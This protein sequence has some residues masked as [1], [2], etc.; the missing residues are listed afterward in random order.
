MN[1]KIQNWASCSFCPYTCRFTKLC[2]P[3][4]SMLITWLAVGISHCV[5]KNVGLEPDDIITCLNCFALLREN[6]I[7]RLALDK[8]Q[9]WFVKCLNVQRQNIGTYIFVFSNVGITFNMP[10]SN[11]LSVHPPLPDVLF[12][13]WFLLLLLQ[14]DFH[15]SDIKLLSILSISSFIWDFQDCFWSSWNPKKTNKQKKSTTMCC[16]VSNLL[17]FS[18]MYQSYQFKVY[19]TSFPGKWAHN[20]P[21]HPLHHP[22]SAA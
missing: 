10:H 17:I 7:D 19:S 14:Y 8:S 5:W 1:L 18:L 4:Q 15:S 22:V 20:L 6:L 9:P 16:Q 13:F 11:M 21:S 3:R 12:F 2:E